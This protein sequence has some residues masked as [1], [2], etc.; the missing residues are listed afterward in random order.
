MSHSICPPVLIWTL[1]KSTSVV[2][3]VPCGHHSRSTIKG[4]V[5]SLLLF[6]DNRLIT[7]TNCSV[8][9]LG[10]YNDVPE[11]YFQ[12]IIIIIS[13]NLLQIIHQCLLATESSIRQN[14]EADF[15]HIQCY[16][17]KHQNKVRV[18]N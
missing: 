11:V 9:A 16:L 13:A 12:L 14:S 8:C 1:N 5:Y 4:G 6:T 18:G 17:S 7:G 15:W 10:K 2:D 3:M